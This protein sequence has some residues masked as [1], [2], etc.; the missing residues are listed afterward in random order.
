MTMNKRLLT[1]ALCCMAAMATT[2]AQSTVVEQEIDNFVNYCGTNVTIDIYHSPQRISYSKCF[3]FAIPN[4]KKNVL[5]LQNLELQFKKRVDDSY[6]YREQKA[7][8]PS[9][10][11]QRVVYGDNNEF[12]IDFFKYSNTNSIVMLVKDS[13]DISRRYAYAMSWYVQGSMLHGSVRIIYGRDPQYAANATGNDG[14]VSP[15]LV[16][17]DAY[18][19][20]KMD[21]SIATDV[22]F[23]KRFGNIRAGIKEN[24]NNALLCTQLTIKLLDLC[25]HHAYLLDEST[26]IMCRAEI[27]RLREEF[28]DDADKAYF[29]QLL[30]MAM[31]CL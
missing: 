27:R 30:G 29:G 24:S 18:T 20:Y 3:R 16:I 11:L 15:S 10:E 6:M 8:R 7:R 5:T 19:D 14:N 4:K 21:D 9:P 2:M 1:G 25:K 26:R 17:R 28:D 13:N 31:D 23:L 12:S 22:D